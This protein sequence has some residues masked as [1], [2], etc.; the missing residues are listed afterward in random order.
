MTIIT[1]PTKG[2]KLNIAKT[3]DIKFRDSPLKV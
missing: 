2:E 3:L 1:Y